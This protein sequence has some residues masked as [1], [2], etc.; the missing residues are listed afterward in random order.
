VRGRLSIVLAALL[1]VSVVYFDTLGIGL[2]WDD[3]LMMRPASLGDVAR[4]FHDTWEPAGVL[5]VYYRPLTVAYQAMV[6]HLLG[7]NPQAIHLL[8]LAWIALAA[9][10][11][12]L[13]VAREAASL[14]TGV[15]AAALYGV[16]PAV[17]RAQ[18]PWFFLQY[19]SL[20]VVVGVIALLVW[21]SRRSDTRPASWWPIFALGAIGFAVREDMAMLVP[22]L[23]VLQAA[24]ARWVRDVPTPAAGLWLTAGALVVVLAAAR[25]WLLSG[26]GGPGLPEGT[27]WWLNAVRGP[28]RTLALFQPASWPVNLIASVVS[29]LVLMRAVF[30]RAPG[31]RAL[32]LTG[33]VVLVMFNLPLVLSS[34][35]ARFHMLALGGVMMLGAGCVGFDRYDGYVRYVGYAAL[36]LLIASFALASRAAIE[37]QRPCG[38]ENLHGDAYVIAW[39]TTSP[40]LRA[41]LIEKRES[42]RSTGRP[43]DFNPRWLAQ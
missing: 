1:G 5:P 40:A 25:Q 2:W 15:L 39:P 31:A 38:A 19:H 18:G 41:W 22:A 9:A 34:S 21:Q 27:E 37:P 36:A 23:V 17:A 32:M 8:S 7:A 35:S 24:R 3:Y 30:I 33:V 26:I 12:G 16:H 29:V 4:S 10:L 43:P 14:R 42:C 28:I 20:C 11:L 13:F 6:V